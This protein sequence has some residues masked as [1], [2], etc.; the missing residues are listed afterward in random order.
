MRE[1][2]LVETVRSTETASAFRVEP[3]EGGEAVDHRLE[4][5]LLPAPQTV[6]EIGL[7]EMRER[8][9]VRAG[10]SPRPRLGRRR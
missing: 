6:A 3:G 7:E 5:R 8:R 9:R 2:E 4:S 10:T 1:G